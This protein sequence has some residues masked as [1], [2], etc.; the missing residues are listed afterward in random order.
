V[1]VTPMGYSHLKHEQHSVI[2]NFIT[3]NDVF[4][5]LPT[6]AME[7][8]CIMYVYQGCLTYCWEEITL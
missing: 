2:I 4:T 1:L 3:G 5:V 8:H 7:N 6:I